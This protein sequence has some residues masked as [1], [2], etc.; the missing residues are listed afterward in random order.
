MCEIIAFYVDAMYNLLMND[1]TYQII[2]SRRKTVQITVKDCMVFVKAPYGYP[3]DGIEKFISEKRDWIV[4]CIEKQKIAA[5]RVALTES[6][7]C[8]WLLGEEFRYKDK[9]NVDV[10]NRFYVEQTDILKTKL[11]E[12]SEKYKFNFASLKFSNAKTL[13]GTCDNRNN[14]RL[15][16]RLSA[17]PMRL[18]EYVIVHELAHTRQHNHSQKFWL[19]VE[20]IMPDYKARRKEL[21]GYSFVLNMYR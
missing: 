20:T 12:V 5:N 2:R 18:I 10:V 21:R 15:N 17:L 1:V 9:L 7:D 19:I 6:A 13:W 11:Y 8:L 4:R 14:I 3:A 16:L